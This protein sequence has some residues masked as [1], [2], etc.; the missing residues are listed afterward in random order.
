LIQSAGD[1]GNQA[2]DHPRSIATR[3]TRAKL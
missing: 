1:V 3:V 2:G